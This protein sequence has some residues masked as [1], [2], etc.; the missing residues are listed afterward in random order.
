MSQTAT[1][2]DWPGDL[3]AAEQPGLYSWWVDESGAK[4]LSDG[5]GCTV[6]AGRIYAGQTGAT[7]WP[8]GKAGTMTLAKRIGRN[9]LNGPSTSR[10]SAS[11]SRPSSKTR[12]V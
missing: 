8:S 1:A 12:Y 4:M 11:Y 3:K 10:R 5:L 2:S 7:K 6:A 9:H